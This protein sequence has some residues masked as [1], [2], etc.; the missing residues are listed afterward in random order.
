MT[1]FISILENIFVILPALLIVAF[2]TISERKT[3]ASMQRRLG[4]VW[5]LGK[6]SLWVK[7][8][9][10]GDFLKLFIPNLNRKIY[11]GWSNYSGKVKIKKIYEN[12]ME[13]RGSKSVKKPVKEQRVDN[14]WHDLICLRYTL[15]N[16]E[17]NYQV[18]IP[19]NQ[20][21]KL[22]FFSSDSN[23]K[24]FKLNSYFLTGFSDAESS[25]IIL[26]LKDKRNK[27][28]WTVKTRF[29]IGL[30]KKDKSTLELIKFY[31]DN[32]GNILKQSKDSLEYRVGSLQDINNIIIPHFDK[33]PLISKKKADFI[34]FKQIINLINN[35]EHLTLEGLQKIVALKASLN[36]GLSDDLKKAFPKII[37]V[38]RP[39]IEK[40]EN[41][42][43]YWLAGFT[44]GEGCFS[45]NLKKSTKY[46]TGFS[47]GLIFKLSQH[48]R[49]K[50]LI[51]SLIK[52]LECG[53]VY[54]NLNSIDYTVYK[55][56]DL[57]YKIVPFFDKYNIIGVKNKDYLLFKEAIQLV[58]KKE[59]LTTKGL[60][61]IFNIKEK[62]NR[63]I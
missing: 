61:H 17:R 34:L 9:N 30:H 6:S 5:W 11:S 53:N 20:I 55:I 4:P 60:N 12:K 63:S 36:L 2:V 32:K 44:S 27:T 47:V 28:G 13:Y 56:E 24:P 10:S 31:F 49:D 46:S 26:I 43:P 25:F 51:E 19:S 1:T 16:F 59:H 54:L 39:L 21:K 8:L 18:K 22:R 45:I 15:M 40:S 38:S 41:I 33:Y 58:K 14:S 29:S 42:D 3:M 35:K 37:A 7:L 23:I 52:Y 48:I 50:E 62:I 57:T